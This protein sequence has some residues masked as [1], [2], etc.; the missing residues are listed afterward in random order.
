MEIKHDGLWGTICDGQWDI[1]DAIVVCHSLGYQFALEAKQDAY[2]GSIYTGQ[3]VYRG[4]GAI[5]MSSVRCRGNETR[6]DDCPYNVI[7]P[8]YC[9]TSDSAGVV[10]SPGMY[11]FYNNNLNIYQIV[12]LTSMYCTG[13]TILLFIS[14]C[15]SDLD[16]DRGTACYD[17]SCRKRKFF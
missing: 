13:Y 17:G 1:F 3:E 14:D 15:A 7:G 12:Y 5:R 9:T 6:L 16:C 11:S 10:F 4:I 2:F 8:H